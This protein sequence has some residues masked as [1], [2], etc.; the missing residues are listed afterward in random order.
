MLSRRELN[1]GKSYVNENE[2]IVCEVIELGRTTVKY[3]SYELSTGKLCGASRVSL[4]NTFIHWADR[5]ATHKEEANLQS[6]EVDALYEAEN[7]IR[8]E[9]A[10]L[11]LEQIQLM[12]HTRMSDRY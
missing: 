3:K 6:H 11:S 10:D 4:K 12:A 9:E 1:V 2:G 8:L 7:Y 5:E